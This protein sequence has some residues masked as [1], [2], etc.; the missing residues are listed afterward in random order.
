MFRPPPLS[1]LLSK[2]HEVLRFY[3]LY[4]RYSLI[5]SEKAGFLIVTTQESAILAE[6]H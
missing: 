6:G 3:V 4:I 1:S 2:R 5:P